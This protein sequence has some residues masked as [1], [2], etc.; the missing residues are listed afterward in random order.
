MEKTTEYV[1]LI[2]GPGFLPIRALLYYTQRIVTPAP[3][4]AAISRGIATTIKRI[5]GAGPEWTSDQAEGEVVAAIERD[6][7]AMI[8]AV[9]VHRV[10][11]MLA[12]FN[13]SEV[14]G[15]AARLITLD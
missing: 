4:R 15:P 6:G 2:P 11:E 12:F 1:R 10:D 14:I 5:Y 8:P 7:L 3:W 13:A 9:P